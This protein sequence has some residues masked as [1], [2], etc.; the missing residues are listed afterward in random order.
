MRKLDAA[1]VVQSFPQ[2][3]EWIQSNEVNLTQLGM[4][5]TAVR[6]KPAPLEL[7]AEVLEEIRNQ[8][9]SDNFRCF[10]DA[11]ACLWGCPEAG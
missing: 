10:A 3:K 9:T 7:Q 2:V 5:Q 4:F 11:A 6:Q 1:R 8:I